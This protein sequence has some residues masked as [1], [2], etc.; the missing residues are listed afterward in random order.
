MPYRLVQEEI[1]KYTSTSSSSASSQGWED[2]YTVAQALL[3]LERNTVYYTNIMSILHNIVYYTNIMSTKGRS[4]IFNMS[5]TFK[6]LV[7]TVLGFPGGSL[8]KE[9]TCNA[10]DLGWEDPLKEGMAA[11]SSVLAWRIPMDKR[12]LVGYSPRGCKESDKTERLSASTRYCTMY[13]KLK[14]KPEMV[15]ALMEIMV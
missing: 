14:T 3:S 7:D 11:H 8:S 1:L 12:S 9:S 2:L 15:P 5:V 13:R 10:G 4:L 6:H